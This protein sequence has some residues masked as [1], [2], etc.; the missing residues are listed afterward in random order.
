[1][2]DLAREF[3]D[4]RQVLG[5]LEDIADEMRE[6]EEALAEGNVGQATQERQLRVYS[7]MLQASRS[8]QRRDFAEQR[9]AGVA[10]ADIFAPPQALPAELLGD[11]TTIEDRL[12]K[13]LSGGYPPQY[14]KQ[15][16]AYF[17]ALM[18]LQSTP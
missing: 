12:R 14:E 7:R 10:P 17:R 8:L 16:K 3:G 13:Y 6:I 18:Q 15:V 4:S 11:K 9:Q 2:E 5:R 1:M